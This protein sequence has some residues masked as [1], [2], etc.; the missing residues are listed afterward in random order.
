MIEVS[1]GFKRSG[2]NLKPKQNIEISEQ[3]S[4]CPGASLGCS[5]SS[6][7]SC[8]NMCQ[9]LQRRYEQTP[10]T[11]EKPSLPGVLSSLSFAIS[12]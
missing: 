10:G 12:H 8:S 1:Q 9:D 6:I 3:R 5:S 2:S 7:L 11:Q 4:C